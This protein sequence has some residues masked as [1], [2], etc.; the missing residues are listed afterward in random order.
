MRKVCDELKIVI[1]LTLGLRSTKEIKAINNIT[2][3]CICEFFSLSHSLGQPS[4]DTVTES[5][6]TDEL[7]S[8]VW[9]WTLG[10]QCP[11]F[12]LFYFTCDL[13]CQLSVF[14]HTEAVSVL[15]RL[16]ISTKLVPAVGTVPSHSGSFTLPST[17]SSV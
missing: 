13:P 14:C 4:R 1:N 16:L 12:F 10:Q 8:Y 2:K 17:V 11:R 15:C 5:E 7:N 9:F 3:I 6:S